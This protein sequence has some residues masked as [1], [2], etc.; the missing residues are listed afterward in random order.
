MKQIAR[1]RDSL[2]TA[3]Y[4]KRSIVGWAV[5][6]FPLTPSPP[7]RAECASDLRGWPSTT[8]SINSP[9]STCRRAPRRQWL[10]SQLFGSL[11]RLWEQ[12]EA[13][14]QAC[15]PETQDAP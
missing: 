7:E 13:L 11:N 3:G 5:S 8:P 15:S 4:A 14:R 12:A 10:H 2:E 1:G 9:Q 6:C